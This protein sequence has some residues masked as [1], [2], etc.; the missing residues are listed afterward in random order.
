MLEITFRT[1]ELTVYEAHTAATIEQDLGA[2]NAFVLMVDFITRRS[3]L[4]PEPGSAAMSALNTSLIM[5]PVSHVYR[6]FHDA[7]MA[8]R[9]ETAAALQ[10]VKQEIAQE[11]IL[12]EAAGDGLEM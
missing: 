8:A 1:D 3:V 4:P 10:R 7:C 9:S 11:V 5:Q 6:L 2:P 12:D